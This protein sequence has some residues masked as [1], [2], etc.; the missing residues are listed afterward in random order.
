MKTPLITLFCLLASSGAFANTTTVNT[1]H[2]SLATGA[3]LLVGLVCLV[4]ARR[5]AA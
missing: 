2:E 1:G 4:I 3:L 5:R